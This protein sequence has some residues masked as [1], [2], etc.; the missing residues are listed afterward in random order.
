MVV[1]ISFFVLE[2]LIL[3]LGV[4]LGYKRG[5]G[6]SVVR[7][8]YLAILGVIALLLG[9][10]I[11]EK[12][13]NAIYAVIRPAL[14]GEVSEILDA[15]PELD[16]L[17]AGLIH[18]LLVP[19]C[20]AVLFGV[21]EALST[22]CLKKLS[23]KIVSAV[24]GK[25]GEPQKKH[26]VIGSVIG[27]ITAFLVFTV[28]FSPFYALMNL[29]GG[30]SDETVAFLDETLASDETAGTA[31][32]QT[33]GLL[34]VSE[35]G[36]AGGVRFAMP[37]L[38]TLRKTSENPLTK[39]GTVF[40]GAL[41]GGKTPREV[42]Y[43]ATKEVP[44]LADIAVV[45]VR[46]VKE[47]KIGSGVAAINHIAKTVLPVVSDSPVGREAVIAVSRAVGNIIRENGSFAGISKNSGN[48]MSDIMV[49]AVADVLAEVTEENLDETA[50]TLFG[51]DIR[52]QTG[53]E[54]TKESETLQTPEDTMKPNDTDSSETTETPTPSVPDVHDERGALEY[55]EQMDF[56][57]PSEILA[58][59]SSY[60][61]LICAVYVVSKNAALQPIVK[62]FGDMGGE[63]F[64]D[65]GTS[66]LPKLTE[67][68][69]TG[70]Y[71]LL[72]S[73]MYDESFYSSDRTLEEK[74]KPIRDAV[75][76]MMT[77]RG[78][79]VAENRVELGAICI[80]AH[81]YTEENLE[82]ITI[83]PEDTV[84]FEEF[85]TYMGV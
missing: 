36:T 84:T 11:A 51:I 1:A 77:S 5:T 45:V 71:T 83:S 9:R 25:D 6:R 33:G 26:R 14:T 76:E 59:E 81:F 16:L 30:L 18:A 17:L 65:S 53:G 44:K 73:S 49:G 32:N 8:I 74:V 40:G 85:R 23:K 75:T 55:L 68:E 48:V 15:S 70:L 3:A 46:D 38:Y 58:D 28:L 67:A 4:F 20:F 35:P 34:S 72:L 63:V 39:A 37:L 79:D 61:N 80:V 31:E 24:T 22:I 21:L 50:K 10:W 52:P 12:G 42:S 43:L 64:G 69:I 7:L 29:C 57:N 27:A 60:D 56:S 19:V 62:A 2:V 41:T 82:K 78:Y 13:G 47:D 54:T 66:P